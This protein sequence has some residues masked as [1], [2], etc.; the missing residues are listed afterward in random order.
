MTL[1]RQSMRSYSMRDVLSIGCMV[2]NNPSK[3]DAKVRYL[4]IRTITASLER[5]NVSTMLGMLQGIHD[6]VSGDEIMEGVADTVGSA[7]LQLR[8]LQQLA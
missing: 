4:D 6:Q 3:G 2:A 7:I 1:I 8:E 5:G